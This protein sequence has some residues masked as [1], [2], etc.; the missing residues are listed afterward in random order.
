MKSFIAAASAALL[1]TSATALPNR[2]AARQ[3]T[4]EVVFTLR[5]DQSGANAN[6]TVP[7]NADTISFNYLFGNSVLASNGRVFASS[8]ELTAF[9][10]GV[11]CGLTD[12]EGRL[13]TTLTPENNYV[14]ID[15]NPTVAVPIDVTEYTIVCSL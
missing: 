11:S 8:A 5:N 12:Y 7:T 15:G 6:A 1:A 9:P 3:V 13:F 4:N 2:I 14:D 10:Q